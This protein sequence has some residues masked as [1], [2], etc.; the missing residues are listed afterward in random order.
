MKI[1]K[2]EYPFFTEIIFLTIEKKSLSEKKDQTKLMMQPA[3]MGVA[4][5]FVQSHLL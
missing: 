5:S 4:N 3:L 1:Y 2:Y